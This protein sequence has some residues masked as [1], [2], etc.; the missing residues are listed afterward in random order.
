MG[1]GK[2]RTSPSLQSPA[3]ARARPASADVWSASAADIPALLTLKTLVAMASYGELGTAEQRAEWLERFCSVSYFAERL[4]SEDTIFLA[5]GPRQRPE[6]MAALKRRDGKAYF[7]DLYV[8]SKR[9]GLG[10]ELFARRVELAR[11]WGLSTAVCDVFSTNAEALA[12]VKEMGFEP[13]SEYEEQSFKIP[14]IRHQRT[15]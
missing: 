4:D 2:R 11:E 12:F 13:V 9:Q 6:A 8:A 5:S 3:S 1:R 10:R 15:L 14:V 7:G